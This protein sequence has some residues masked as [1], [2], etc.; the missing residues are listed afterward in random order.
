MLFIHSVLLQYFF[1]LCFCATF[2]LGRA[3][4][5]DSHGVPWSRPFFYPKGSRVLPT[6]K[7]NIL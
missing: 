7:Q 6:P 4:L 3:E 1:Q 2:A 5:Q